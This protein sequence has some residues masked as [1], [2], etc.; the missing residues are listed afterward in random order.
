VPLVEVDIFQADLFEQLGL[1][2]KDI[3]TQ[4]QPQSGKRA[5]DPNKE[6]KKEMEALAT[7]LASIERNQGKPQRPPPQPKPVDLMNTP[8]NG[9]EKQ[10]LKESIPELTHQQ[11]SGILDIV[12]DACDNNGAKDDVFEFELD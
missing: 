12:R 4:T 7:K 8:M 2:N 5:T 11:Q 6:I 3:F 1:L 9:R 10:A